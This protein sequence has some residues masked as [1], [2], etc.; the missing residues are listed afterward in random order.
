MNSNILKLEKKY[1]EGMAEKNFETVKN[2]TYFPCIVAGKSGVQSV[3][4]STFKKMFESGNDKQLKVQDISNVEV[5]VINENTAVIAYIITIAY[6]SDGKKSLNNCV[7]SSTWI[8][9]N[10][11]WLCALHTETDLQN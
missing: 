10:G 9:E 4:E 6:S 8:M 7:C 5:Q 3:D 1:W 2:L 11:N